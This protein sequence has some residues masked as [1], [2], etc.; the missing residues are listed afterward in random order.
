[1]K[2]ISFLIKSNAPI[3]IIFYFIKQ[4]FLNIFV[5]RKIIK[6]KKNHQKNIKNKKIS[7]DYFSAHAYNFSFYLGQLKRDF[8][9]LEIGSYEGNSAIFVANLYP[10]SR[11]NCVDTWQKTNEYTNHKSFTKIEDNFD[12]NTLEYKNILKNKNTSDSFFESNLSKFDVVYID[13]YHYGPQVYKDCVNAWEVLKENGLL[14]CDDYIWEFYTNAQNNPCY[15]I[16]SFLRKINGLYKI[17]K[18]SNSQIFIKKN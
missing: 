7:I 15:A 9:Y 12:Y 16:N 17:E 1:M 4:K 18:I 6:Y 3:L 11:I 8:D 2:K 14:I 13:G 10:H 5:K